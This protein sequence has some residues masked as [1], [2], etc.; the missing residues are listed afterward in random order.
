[1]ALILLTH[2]PSV[3]E[4]LAREVATTLS[5]KLGTRVEVGSVS[6][7]L[8][9]TAT[10]DTLLIY[11]QQGR[12]LLRV[13]RAIGTVELLPLLR[14][15]VNVTSLRVLGAKASLY[16]DTPTSQGNWQF[17]VDSLMPKPGA[18]GPELNLRALLLRDM[19]LT[20]DVLD[21]PRSD[22]RFDRNH[23]DIER[24]NASLVLKSLDKDNQS[25]RI[26]NME[27][28]LRNGM[29]IE[30][31]RGTIE[32][33]GNGRYTAD[34]P[35]LELRLGNNVLLR[36]KISALLSVPENNALAV[37][38]LQSQS[39]LTAGQYYYDINLSATHSNDG[40]TRPISAD[41]AIAGSRGEVAKVKLHSATNLGESVDADFNLRLSR[42]EVEGV[43]SAFGAG[44]PDYPLLTLIDNIDQSGHLDI[45]HSKILY[46]GT[47]K[48]NLCDLTADIEMRGNAVQY[49]IRD[50]AL[51][52]ETANAENC[53]LSGTLTLDPGNTISEA[54]AKASIG[55]ATYGGY[56]L[57]NIDASGQLHGGDIIAQL[58]IN[59]S[60]LKLTANG[61]HTAGGNIDLTGQAAVMQGR[62]AALG[63]IDFQYKSDNRGHHATIEGEGLTATLT[64]NM[65]PSQT[66]AAVEQ[67]VTRHL[68]ELHSTFAYLGIAMQGLTTVEKALMHNAA[69]ASDAPHENFKLNFNN[70]AL[71]SDILQDDVA[72]SRP[73]E[74]LGYVNGSNQ[75]TTL[76]V[77]A[78][79]FEIG[80]NR[81]DLTSAYINSSTD[82]LGGSLMTTKY[83]GTMPVRIETH[84]AGRDDKIF[85]EMLWRNTASRTTYGTLRTETQLR[86][87]DHGG[88]ES[89]TQVLPTTLY[90]SDTPWQV[91]P[92]TIEYGK[93]LL[94]IS[95]LAV[96]RGQQYLSIN[97][98]ILD[99]K[100]DLQVQLNDVEVAYLLGLTNFKPVE[101]GGKASGIIRNSTADPDHR[102]EGD[103]VVRD[104]LFNGAPL[105]ILNANAYFDI[106]DSRLTIKA[107]AQATPDDSTLIDGLVM[108][109][110]KNLDFHFQS[111]KTNL[112]FLNKYVGRFIDDLEGNTT[113]HFHLFG[114]F[115]YVQMEAD[116]VINYLKLRPKMLGALY[117]TEAQL[118]HIRP[119]TIDFNGF[120]LRDTYGNNATVRG[121]VNHHYLFNFNYNL[122][123]D[124][125]NLLT[126][127]WQEQPSRSFWGSVAA[128]GNLNL[129]GTTRDVFITGE[130]TAVGEEGSS[131]LYYNSN[132]A[133]GD[134]NR[135]FV[136]FTPTPAQLAEAR[137]KN[138][139]QHATTPSGGGDVNIDLKINAT[140]DATLNIVTDPVTRDYMSLRGNGPLQLNYYN[141]GRFQLNGLY[142]V[143]SGRYKLTIKDIIQKNFDIQQGGYLRF[144]GTPSEADINLKGVHRVNSVSLSDLNVGASQTNSTIGVDCIL[145]FTGKAAEPKVSFDID[146]PR[147]NQDEATLLKR[148][149]LTEEDRNMQAVY[150]LSIGR[151]YTYNYNDFSSNTGGQNQSTVAMTSLLAGTLS[152]QINNILQDAFRVTNW[153]VG[154]S[155]AAGRMG[156]NDMEVQG[157]LSGKMFNNRLLF[158]GNI[159]YR[160]QITTYSNNLV[161]DFNLQ[162]LLNK[163]GTISLKAY[164]E[165]NDRY[166]TKSSLT[167]QGGGILFQKDFRKL[168]D[169]F[170]K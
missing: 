146:F 135:D 40:S 106:P 168:R 30:E 109:R 43:L 83:F 23:I 112:Q 117:T 66:I 104:F 56:Q 17:A 31:L 88:I 7:D 50:L 21:Q 39:M 78:P 125:N 130:L 99:D 62:L 48:S 82:S 13:D 155:I 134:E 167:T 150:L 126:I 75:R 67:Q 133:G 52:T 58:N 114:S 97:T 147:A 20:Y 72:L 115:K 29:G 54:V 46:S 142:T 169:F 55:S 107:K 61:Q 152:G 1:M 38:K 140:P 113:G 32:A 80:G 123:F 42:D 26:R 14:S 160:D 128:D 108:L 81:Y 110:D 28:R 51:R 69:E 37:E 64:G 5:D 12:E 19:A 59:D 105:G 143:N 153:S 157:S 77:S 4:R 159:G 95:N 68:P 57:S 84:F 98:D 119:D 74:V 122:D 9:N 63:S 18:K 144:N 3:K 136:R 137:A 25:A 148:Y 94:R 96:S 131:A 100:K 35:S 53:N 164:S 6:V 11:D 161:G 132:A 165:T 170:K 41:I 118:F 60:Q 22:S 127:N 10:I 138:E 158:N 87:A 124:L 45:N 102:L 93:D 156:F 73:I 129:H 154:T 121:S 116:E 33:S 101:F 2:L 44:L 71:L 15:K 76:T 16:R 111:E 151:F 70:K 85:S 86:H 103:L 141:K 27:M 65:L 145:N 79:A 49:D 89:V 166:F 149:I 120:V 162:W 36:S 8:F 139:D 163:S 24:L 47:T 91:S 34:I 92:A 90:I